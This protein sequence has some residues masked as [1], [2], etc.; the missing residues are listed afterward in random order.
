VAGLFLTAPSTEKK[1]CLGGPGEK[2]K[3]GLKN[4]V[5]PEEKDGKKT[6]IRHHLGV[7]L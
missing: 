1:G 3:G 5:T 7:V 4:D 2:V 6:R